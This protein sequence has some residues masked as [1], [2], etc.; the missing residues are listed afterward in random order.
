MKSTRKNKMA[1]GLAK[2]RKGIKERPSE[3]KNKANQKIALNRWKKWRALK[4]LLSG[5]SKEPGVYHFFKPKAVAYEAILF[6]RDK[7]LY[8]RAWIKGWKHFT[9]ILLGKAGGP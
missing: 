7:K 4:K 8:G 9:T 2:L 5:L 1:V 3:K 6:I